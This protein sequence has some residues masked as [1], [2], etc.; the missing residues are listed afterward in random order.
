QRKDRIKHIQKKYKY[1]DD[2]LLQPDHVRCYVVSNCTVKK[3]NVSSALGIEVTSFDDTI[4]Q[5]NQIQ[6]SI[7]FGVE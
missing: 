4:N 6:Q 7:L 1:L 2:E 3:M 5:V